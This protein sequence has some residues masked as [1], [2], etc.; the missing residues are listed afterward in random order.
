MSTQLLYDLLIV[1]A[2]V[3][4]WGITESI[5]DKIAKNDN[6]VRFVVYILVSLIAIFAIWI[7][8]VN[9]APGNNNF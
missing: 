2:W 6:N 4:L 5:I 8:D 1:V 9:R 7:L 3:G